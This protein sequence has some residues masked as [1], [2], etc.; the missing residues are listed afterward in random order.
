MK[1]AAYLHPGIFPQGP[2][3]NEA[4][5]DILGRMLQA[6]HRDAGRECMLISGARFVDRARERGK[7]GLFDGIRVAEIDEIALLRRINRD[8]GAATA[9]DRLTYGGPPDHPAL[10]ALAAEVVRASGAFTPDVLI[11]FAVPTDFLADT[12]PAT[13]RLHVEAGPFSR[14]PFPG[15][16]FLDHLGMYN[17]SAIRQVGSQP[18]NYA[19]D[20]AATALVSAVRT[21]YAA[22]LAR[23]D[24]FAEIDLRG[25]FERVCLLPLQVSDWYGF[26]EQVSYRTQFELLLD[27]LCAAP[28]DVRIIVTEYAQWGPVITNVGLTR[29]L[30]YLR[31]AFPN[32]LFVEPF[33]SYRSPSQFLVPRVDGVWTVSSNVGY[34]ALLFEHALGTPSST[35]LAGIAHS[36][37]F[38]D[39]FA[40]LGRE[41]QSRDAFLAWLLERYLVPECLWADGAW[42]DEYLRRRLAASRAIEDPIAAFVPIADIDRLRRA[43]INETPEPIAE[44]LSSPLDEIAAE[45]AE[46]RRLIAAIHG[47]TSWQITAPMRALASTYRAA[48]GKARRVCRQGAA[49][50]DRASKPSFGKVTAYTAKQGG[51]RII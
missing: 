37:G 1:V 51:R 2:L 21:H 13:L 43:W 19:A 6:L 39:F 12:W 45:L 41:V 11:S 5:I 29:N 46:S 47:S 8:T 23:L 50:S 28:P 40:R 16:L 17:G 31:D 9:L 35:H 3:W 48:L 14:N 7:G 32:M 4:W 30:D 36:T 26:D 49:T 15:S 44:T 25:P 27:V 34:Q 24:P 33:R 20:P 18:I 22:I 42:L 10:R 38:T